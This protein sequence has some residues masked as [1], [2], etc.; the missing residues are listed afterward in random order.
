MIFWLA[1]ST[2]VSQSGAML[3]N[4]HPIAAVYF[5]VIPI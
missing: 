1:G 5:G 2:T 4:D 3:E